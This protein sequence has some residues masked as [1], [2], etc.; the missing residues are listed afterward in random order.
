MGANDYNKYGGD[1]WMANQTMERSLE[2]S[3]Y[4]VNHVWGDGAHSSKQADSIFPDAMRWLWKDW[5]QPVKAGVSQNQMLQEILVPNET[6]QAVGE[7]FGRTDGAAANL[8]GEVFFSDM[9]DSKTF[10]ITT[11]GNVLPAES[12][13]GVQAF[14]AAAQSH[15]LDKNVDGV[16][17][18]LVVVH[19]GDL[20]MT[21]DPKKA[22]DEPSKVWLI[23]SSGEKSVVDEGLKFANGIALSPD[24]TLLYVSDYRSH[25]VYSYQIQPDGTLADKQQYYWLHTPDTA[26]DAGADGMCVDTDG[27]LYVSTR[28]GIQVCDQAGRVNCILPT[29]NGKVSS[30]CI[31]GERFDTLFA[32]CGDKVFKRKLNVHG[33]P[34]WAE[35]IKPA[36]P[37][38]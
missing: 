16:P 8:K 36:P 35:P 34:G 29:P 20:Y 14:D 12:F 24:Q 33:Q 31:G 6:W 13:A 17:N 21:V 1:W 32:A 38:L 26:D 10:K 4:E 5:P 11:D 7:R 22:S 27:R 19:N 30:L 28:M 18:D 23:K 3:G 9:R 2:F 25:W 15:Q 37:K